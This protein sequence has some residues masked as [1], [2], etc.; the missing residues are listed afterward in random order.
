M[1]TAPILK[2]SKINKSFGPIDVPAAWRVIV[3]RA[4]AKRPE[5]RYQDARTLLGALRALRAET[6]AAP[7]LSGDVHS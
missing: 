7:A 3:E 2:L 4:L 6:P 5:D 1:M